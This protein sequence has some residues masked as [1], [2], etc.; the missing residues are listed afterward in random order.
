MTPAFI[1]SFAISC[2]VLFS[3]GSLTR[4]LMADMT[5]VLLFSVPATR[6]TPS[7]SVRCDC[8]EIICALFAYNRDLHLLAPTSSLASILAEAMLLSFAASLQSLIAFFSSRSKSVICRSSF[9]ISLRISRCHF[10]TSSF[11]SGFLNIF[12]KKTIFAKH[13]GLFRSTTAVGRKLL[14]F[15]TTVCKVCKAPVNCANCFRCSQRIVFTKLEVQKQELQEG[16]TKQE[17]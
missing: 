13:I 12:F 5:P 11:G 3:S 16:F 1:I 8:M 4:S 2:M 15:G 7:C 10:L 6:A 14:E 17:R 9:L